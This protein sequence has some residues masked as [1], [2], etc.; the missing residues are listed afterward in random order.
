MSEINLEWF[1]HVEDTLR[2]GFCSPDVGCSVN[3]CACATSED[4]ADAIA[5]L[6]S[7]IA[8]LEKALE[9]FAEAA[10]TVSPY[11]AE[12]IAV[13]IEACVAARAVLSQGERTACQGEDWIRATSGAVSYPIIMNGDH[14]EFEMQ[15]ADTKPEDR[16]DWPLPSFDAQD[17]AKAFLKAYEAGDDDFLT[18]A[19]MI[20]WFAN[21]LM[22][23]HDHATTARDAGSLRSPEASAFLSD[24]DAEIVALV[25]KHAAELFAGNCAFADDDL[26]LMAA[27]AKWAL[28]N[29]VPDEINPQ[30]IRKAKAHQRG[31][32]DV[33]ARYGTGFGGMFD[34]NAS[35]ER[36]GDRNA[37]PSVT[38]VVEPKP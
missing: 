4:G 19:T 28:N 17:W 38:T 16:P 8:E 6:R 2:N 27:C 22:R 34:P 21:A 37:S 18:E 12:R 1:R 35:P 5:S 26:D 30:I 9:P 25:R 15:H 10:D 14:A 24:M 23:G 29:G 3:T 33:P 13:S 36:D 31:E 32:Q 20:G 11:W 7:R